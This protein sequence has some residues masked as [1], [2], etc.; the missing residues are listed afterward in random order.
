M[1]MIRFQRIGK[2][3]HPSYRLVVS[4][5]AKDTQSGSL[6]N[7]GVYN[8]AVNPKVVDLRKDRIAHWMSVGAQLSASVNNLFINQG[9]IKGDKK[10]SVFLSKKRKEKLE[11]AKA[12]PEEKKA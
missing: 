8:P 5:K 2:K 12:V 3:K 4:E 1:L 9:L 11:K 6:E 7:L 10:K